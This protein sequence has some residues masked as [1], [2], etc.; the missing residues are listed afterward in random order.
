L[1]VKIFLSRYN[2][3]VSSVVIKTKVQTF[4]DQN[5][6]HSFQL[7]DQ[8]QEYQDHDQKVQDQD[9]NQDQKVQD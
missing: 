3:L 4:Q 9:Q 6:Y 7:K 1:H 5:Q 2:E 8:D